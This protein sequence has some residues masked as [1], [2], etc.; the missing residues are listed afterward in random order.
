MRSCF[1]QLKSLDIPITVVRGVTAR[2]VRDAFEME[3]SVAC[4]SLCNTRCL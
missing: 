2:Q 1:M 4:P 3:K